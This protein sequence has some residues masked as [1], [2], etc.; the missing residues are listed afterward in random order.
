MIASFV[1]DNNILKMFGYHFCTD[2]DILF[3]RFS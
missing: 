3:L 1:A 2:E